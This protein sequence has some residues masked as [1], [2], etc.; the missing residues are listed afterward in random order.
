M[1]MDNQYKVATLGGGCFWCLEAVYLE[2]KGVVEVVS[3]YSGGYIDE[4]TY[5]Q[6]C[7]GSTGHAE[8]VQIKFDL[9]EVDFQEILKIFFSIHDPTTVNKQGNDIGS[10]Y[11]SIIF[12]HDNNQLHLSQDT[13]EEL[14]RDGLWAN[15]IVTEIKQVEIFYPAEDYHQNYYQLNPNNSYCQFVISPKLTK[16]RNQI[17]IR[18]K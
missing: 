15:P 17:R 3:G 7:T 4:P 1:N 5:E 11:R 8:V 6:I 14:T 18:Q 12:Y 9:N 16:F 2:V 10:Q 13:I